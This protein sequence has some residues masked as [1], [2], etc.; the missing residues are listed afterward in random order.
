VL[1]NAVHGS[2]SEQQMADAKAAVKASQ[3]SVNMCR[4]PS[5]ISLAD[6]QPGTTS[7]P[8]SVSF[9]TAMHVCLSHMS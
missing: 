9:C 4:A 1:N 7:A 3:D 2:F 5:R 6:P 8:E